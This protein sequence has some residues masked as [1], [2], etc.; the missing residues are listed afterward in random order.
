[1][2]QLAVVKILRRKVSKISS[3]QR[4]SVAII[5]A[6]A[7]MAII[8]ASGFAIDYSRAA[9]LKT[10]LDAYADAAALNA[11]SKAS[12]SACFGSSCDSAVQTAAVAFFNAQVTNSAN[13]LKAGS[14]SS[15]TASVVDTASTN[16]RTATITYTASIPTVF[17]NIAGINSLAVS[18][19]ANPS[20]AQSAVPT[21]MDFYMLLD[22]TP[23]M[24]IGATATDVATMVANTP[25]Q[26]GFAC[27]TTS[28]AA[29]NYYAI[30]KA[31][32]VTMRID[33]VAQAVAQLT[34][35]ATSMQV[36]SNQFRM[37][38]YDFGV[39]ASSAGLNQVF[40]LSSSMSA[41]QTAA[42][43]IDLMTI[44]YQNYNN[45]Q[46]T[47]FDSVLTALNAA[48]P[49]PGAGNGTNPTYPQKWVFF[50]T[51]GVADVNAPAWGCSEKTLDNGLGGRC[52]EPLN[53]SNC[54]TMKSRGINIAVLYTT[55]QQLPTNSWYMTY[56][57][58]FNQ[59]PWGP[60][61]NSQIAQNLQACASPGY[62][63]EVS[64]TQGIAAAINELFQ[65]A[66]SNARLTQ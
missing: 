56:I 61:P 12:M 26:C 11:V 31:H 35:T 1:M 41:A 21:Y 20:V 5:F 63:T 53:V 3:D 33:V 10:T 28:D 40:A 4:G 59:G 65:K 15:V 49:T 58:P 52:M 46:Q 55:Y 7:S 13:A 2:M 45:D 23:S 32:G 9:R 14:V 42:N 48:I 30:A 18:N 47:D 27:H 66:I 22:N 62:Y 34:S 57:D 19:S 60:S 37:A 38:I 54:T 17:I 44:P 16:N 6:I 25:D 39:D 24:G 50:V 51:D 8:L 43:G 29:N 64:P 36:V